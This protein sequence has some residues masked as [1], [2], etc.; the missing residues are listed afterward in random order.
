[1]E[2]MRRSTG[3]DNPAKAM[4]EQ[5]EAVKELV[6][7]DELRRQSAPEVSESPPPPH[8]AAPRMQSARTRLS[9]MPRGNR[10]Q[11]WSERDKAFGMMARRRFLQD[12]LENPK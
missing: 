3:L 1:M 5:N 10:L 8:A 11:E 9:A 4:M 12:R 2:G 6:H 7:H